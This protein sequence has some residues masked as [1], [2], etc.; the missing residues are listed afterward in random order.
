MI[1][2]AS[3]SVIEAKHKGRS[4]LDQPEGW[5]SG[6]LFSVGRRDDVYSRAA[7][8]LFQVLAIGGLRFSIWLQ[9]RSELK[10]QTLKETLGKSERRSGGQEEEEEEEEGE[11]EMTTDL[12]STGVKKRGW[13]HSTFWPSPY[14]PN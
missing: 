3:C 13:R 11:K 9:R 14:L 10:R 1:K 12:E 4:R 2:E 7:S 6:C 8:R 5:E